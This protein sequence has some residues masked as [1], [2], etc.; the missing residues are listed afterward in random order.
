[1]KKKIIGNLI[2]SIIILV[3][4]ILISRVPDDIVRIVIALCTGTIFWN[5]LDIS[6]N[7]E[8]LHKNK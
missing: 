6:K 2:C 4:L 5:T 1:M 7:Y 3:A 8:I